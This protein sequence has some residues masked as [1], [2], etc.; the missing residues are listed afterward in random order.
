MHVDRLLVRAV[1]GCWP[2]HFQSSLKRCFVFACRTFQRIS[3]ATCIC[4]IYI[5]YWQ[6]RH[7]ITA[8]WL[9]C[10]AL[11]PPREAVAGPE[12]VEGG[13]RVTYMIG[14]P[15]TPPSWLLL[16]IRHCREFP[17]FC[18]WF[19]KNPTWFRGT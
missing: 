15:I 4:A 13:Q 8:Y 2:G 9:R 11:P 7:S 5:F 14:W 17:E 16:W 6:S 19:A 18:H 10:R 12:R 1:S 3:G